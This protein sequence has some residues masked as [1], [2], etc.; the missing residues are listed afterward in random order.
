MNL[1]PTLILAALVA[2]LVAV[3]MPAFSKASSS[4]KNGRIAFAADNVHGSAQVFTVNPDGTRLRQVTH[5]PL[6]FGTDGLSWSPDGRDL[7]FVVWHGGNGDK[8]H[9]SRADGSGASAISPPCE[10]EC[11]GDDDPAYSPDGKKIAFERALGP[12]LNYHASVV[13]IFTMDADGNHLAQ[14]TQTSTPTSSDDHAPDW[15]PDG[16]KIA[17]V[18]DNTTATPHSKGA[19]EVMNADGSNVQRLTPFRIDAADPH[20]SPNGKQIL[21]NTHGHAAQGKSANLFTMH[22]NGTHRAPLTHYA[23]GTL[24]AFADDWSP[25]GRQIVFHRLAF[26]G[27]NT[28]RDHF[29][30]LDLRTMHIRRLTRA[31]IRGYA[32]AAWGK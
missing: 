16:T 14:L 5:D 2:S 28:E 21:F 31:R 7:L 25:D 19:I 32:R 27:T 6:T 24:Q 13:A 4:N 20:W 18:R 3:L 10:G 11:L 15:S 22:A 8:I 23:G 26:S 1:R 12:F 30:I 9:K 17:F 29:Y